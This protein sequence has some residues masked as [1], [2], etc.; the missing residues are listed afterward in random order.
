MKFTIYIIIMLLALLG[1]SCSAIYESPD[2]CPPPDGSGDVLISFRMITPVTEVASRADDH[3]HDEVGSEYRRFEDGL[4]MSDVALFIFAGMADSTDEARLLLKVTDLSAAS[5][6]SDIEVLGIPGSYIVNLTIPQT[7]LQTF[8]GREIDANSS[9]EVFFR[10]LMVANSSAGTSG[11]ASQWDAI[12]ATTFPDV[13]SQLDNL[14]TFPMS[15][16]CN[17]NCD[18]SI[19]TDYGDN[20][21]SGF[22]P[23]SRTCMPMFGTIE[24]RLSQQILLNSTPLHRA[25]LPDMDMLRSLAKVRLIDNIDNKS[26]DGYP[27]VVAAQ[28]VGTQNAIHQ[29]PFGAATYV[30]GN[31]VHSP[32][33]ADPDYDSASGPGFIYCLGRMPASITD[34]PSSQRKGDVRVGYVPE[35]KILPTLNEN[36]GGLPAFRIT[37]AL[38]KSVDGTEITEEYLVPMSRFPGFGGNILRNHIYTLSVDHVTLQNL[39]LNITVNHWD[40]IR[41]IYEY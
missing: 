11:D 25:M 33:F 6:P 21:V 23:G 40:T 4:D 22:Y 15:L 34:V 9:E 10:V 13:I 31:Q 24:T 3:G 35:M 5:Q 1:A 38:S 39:T 14:P 36:L 17:F 32:Y 41:F 27:K 18:Y 29:L 30:N 28:L 20:T 16:L 37:M 2:E 12:T 7:Q 19:P 8:L 26:A